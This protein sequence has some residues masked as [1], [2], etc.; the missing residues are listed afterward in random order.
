MPRPGLSQSCVNR[1]GPEIYN[2]MRYVNYATRIVHATEAGSE[3]E[4]GQMCRGHE[5]AC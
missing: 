3:A 4:A 1:S 5:Y 2:F